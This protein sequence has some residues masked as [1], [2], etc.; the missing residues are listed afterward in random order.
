MY[1]QIWKKYLPIIRI[2]IKKAVSEP[3]VLELNKIDFE[4]AGTAR[5]AISKFNILL[6]KGKVANIISGS[7]LATDLAQTMLD[8]EKIK[9]LCKEYSFQVALNTKYQLTFQLAD[10]K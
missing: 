8:D 1:H 2:L 9:E 10:Q 4:R 3:Q 7:Q 6:Q 5:K